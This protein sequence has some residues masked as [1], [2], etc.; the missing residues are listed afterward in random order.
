M[1]TSLCVT[2][3]RRDR[4]QV[5]FCAKNLHWFPNALWMKSEPFSM[6]SSVCPPRPG[7]YFLPISFG[8]SCPRLC[9]VTN[10]R[11]SSGGQAGSNNKDPLGFHFLFS[12]SLSNTHTHTHTHAHAHT[13]I[14]SSLGQSQPWLLDSHRE[15]Q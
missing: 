11:R 1:L 13:R 12:L 14:H 6:E 2:A 10:Y 7:P 9:W 3:G 4:S 8:D 15:S 5:H